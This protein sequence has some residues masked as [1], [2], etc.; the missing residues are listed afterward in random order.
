MNK[1]V[2]IRFSKRMIQIINMMYDNWV[3]KF[4][5]LLLGIWCASPQPKRIAHSTL[6][7]NN[8]IFG[9]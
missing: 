7:C 9:M 8:V 3:T 5:L 4:I 2:I 1:K 6:K